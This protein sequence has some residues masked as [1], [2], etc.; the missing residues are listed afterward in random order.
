MVD[1]GMKTLIIFIL[2][3]LIIA[4]SPVGD[5]EVGTVF[6]HPIDALEVFWK[7]VTLQL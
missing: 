3:L 6:T 2:I 1:L 5:W 7:W 4:Q